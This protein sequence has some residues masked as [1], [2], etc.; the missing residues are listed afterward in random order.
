MGRDFTPRYYEIEQFLR[1]L[2]GRSE[3]GDGL[4]SEN[5]L[6]ER[7]S[8]SRMTARHA[9]QRLVQEG[10]IYRISGH[11]SFVANPAVHR[12]ANKLLSFS[13]E[14]RLRGREPSSRVLIFQQRPPSG[15]ER[16][17]LELTGDR[18]VVEI[19][20]VRLADGVPIAHERAVVSPRCQGLREEQLASASL[21]EVLRGLGFPPARGRATLAAEAATAEDADL[22]DVELGS[23]MLVE[24]RLIRDARDEPLEYTCSRYAGP[25]YML[26]VEFD[27]VDT[28]A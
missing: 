25:R 16:A 17:S 6:C 1:D 11:G 9:M 18:D 23:S 21:H 26:D 2:I 7:F 8:V 10:M 5:E 14:M 28:K 27:V 12:Q 13:A 3:P 4:P 20:R 22:L 15:E 19:H 24:R